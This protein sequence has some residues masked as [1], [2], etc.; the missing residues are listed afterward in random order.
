MKIDFGSGH[1]PAPGY[2]T[3]DCFIPHTDIAYDHVNYRI[4]VPDSS[5]DEIRC[6][7]VLH[8]VKDLGR[9]FKE[10]ARVLKRGGIVRVIEPHQDAFSTNVLLDTI[11]YRTVQP[12]PEIWF[13]KEY[14]D[15]LKPARNAGFGLSRHYRWE[16]KEFSIL[17][18]TKKR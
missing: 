6:R 13:S 9:L 14:R 12:R 10:F 17:V 7:N 18:N 16:E 8:H 3:C 4:D 15:Y 11:W 5:V 2:K 1:K